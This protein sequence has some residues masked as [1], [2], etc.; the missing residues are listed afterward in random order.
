LKTSFAF[1][2]AGLLSVNVNAQEKPH[3]FPLSG[4]Q[5]NTTESVKK[6]EVI[7]KNVAFHLA[8]KEILATGFIYKETTNPY[9]ML[10]EHAEQ[11]I[12]RVYGNQNFNIFENAEIE[13]K[14]QNKNSVGLEYLVD[15]DG[16]KCELF[17]ASLV[18][19]QSYIFLMVS[20]EAVPLNC[21]SQGAQL[22]LSAKQV[23]ESITIKDM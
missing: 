17:L 2:L 10:K 15:L 6:I 19:N 23:T 1:V 16:G 3:N 18:G 14:L 7:G 21:K 9:P 11:F 4:L 12:H 22:K 13:T 8:D 20:N 5:L